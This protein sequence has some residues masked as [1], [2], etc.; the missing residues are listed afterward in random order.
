MVY[1]VIILSI[2]E[3]GIFTALTI[4]LEMQSGYSGANSSISS[5][6][7][8]STWNHSF[9]SFNIESKDFCLVLVCSAVLWPLLIYLPSTKNTL[10]FTFVS[11][12]II[13]ATVTIYFFSPSFHLYQPNFF[14][15]I[16][17][18]SIVVRDL[19]VHFAFLLAL[20]FSVSCT[21]SWRSAIPATYD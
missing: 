11:I 3:I 18:L 21:T 16:A 9:C 2:I 15:F 13:V 7:N 8:H 1:H 6:W 19:N 14:Y 12:V 17:C 4:W 10:K 20:S 5:T